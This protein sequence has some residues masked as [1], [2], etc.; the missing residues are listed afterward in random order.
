MPGLDEPHTLASW[1]ADLPG[2]TNLPRVGV[3]DLTPK[4]AIHPMPS[5]PTKGR[6]AIVTDAGRDAVDADAPQDERR[7]KRPA[8]SCGPD[9]PTLVSS[10]ADQYPPGDGGKKSPVTGEHDISVKTMARGMPGHRGDYGRMLI[11]FCMRGCGRS[12]RPALPAPSVL[13]AD[14]SCKT[15]AYRAA[16][17]RRCV[18]SWLFEISSSG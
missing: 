17:S 15:R 11:L 7:V 10:L 9:A 2:R 14:G 18:L 13:K 16:R 4:S 12:E 8:K 3:I 5:R 1:S 6:L